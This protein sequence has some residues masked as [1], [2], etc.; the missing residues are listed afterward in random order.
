MPSL[1]GWFHYTIASHSISG[2][3][4]TFNESTEK[5]KECSVAYDW[6]NSRYEGNP[7]AFQSMSPILKFI[8]DLLPKFIRKDIQLD[9]LKGAVEY[10]WK[11]NDSDRIK[12]RYDIRYPMKTCR[13]NET[14]YGMESCKTLHRVWELGMKSTI[15]SK[16]PILTE[17]TQLY[18]R[19]Q[20]GEHV[21]YNTKNNTS[22]EEIADLIRDSLILDRNLD[23]EYNARYVRTEEGFPC[24]YSNLYDLSNFRYTPTRNENGT[25][26]LDLLDK[27]FEKDDTII[28]RG[29]AGFGKSSLAHSFAK[30]KEKQG[31]IIRWIDAGTEDKIKDAYVQMLKDMNMLYILQHLSFKER[32]DSKTLRELLRKNLLRCK[33]KPMLFIYDNVSDYTDTEERFLNALPDISKIITT[34]IAFPHGLMRDRTTI[35][36]LK[37]FSKEEAKSYLINNL[38]DTFEGNID[39]DLDPIVERLSARNETLP[40]RLNC[41]INW[42]LHELDRSLGAANELIENGTCLGSTIRLFSS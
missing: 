5:P 31:T 36:H 37:M 35:V 14:Y 6:P 19:T 20:D 4:A 30:Q 2:I 22:V 24:L 12:T 13:F 18:E 42:L 39:S 8:L 25:Y 10:L 9:E 34:R 1:S 40:I 29:M 26:Y 15:I 33:E 23:N 17:L 27:V 21:A 41:I 38:K 32:S 3:L 28:I 7:G 16:Y 11:R